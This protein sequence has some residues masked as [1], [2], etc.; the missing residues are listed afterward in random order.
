MFEPGTYDDDFRRRDATST[1]T[2][3]LPGCDHVET[4]LSP[5]EILQPSRL[6]ERGW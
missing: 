4:W 3:G 5:D 1:T 6:S 2:R